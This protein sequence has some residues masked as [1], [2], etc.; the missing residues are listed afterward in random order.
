MSIIREG[1]CITSGRPEGRKNFLILTQGSGSLRK[2]SSTQQADALSPTSPFLLQGWGVGSEWRWVEG[3][4]L[5]LALSISPCGVVGTG[6]S[7]GRL[8]LRKWDTNTTKCLLLTTQ[9][10]S[11]NSGAIGNPQL[12]NPVLVA[13]EDTRDSCGKPCLS[14]QGHITLSQQLLWLFIYKTIQIL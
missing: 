3:L 7:L 2:C 12:V 10:P 4:I 11:C 13:S 9:S 14:S 8:G 6:A 1:K 5:E